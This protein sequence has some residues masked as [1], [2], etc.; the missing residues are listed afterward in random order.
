MK[1]IIPPAIFLFGWLLPFFD[2]ALDPHP[3]RFFMTALL[4]T[5]GIPFVFCLCWKNSK[6]RSGKIWY[7]LFVLACLFFC[8]LPLYLMYWLR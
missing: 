6:S 2:G 4:V 8:P 5:G 7:A 1:T 3:Y